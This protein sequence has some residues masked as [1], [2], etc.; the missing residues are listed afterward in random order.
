MSILMDLD[1]YTLT[2][3]AEASGCSEDELL[4]FGST[5]KL[6]FYI[7]PKNW[8]YSEYIHDKKTAHVLHLLRKPIRIDNPEY[9]SCLVQGITSSMIM[10]DE[11]P[12]C[13]LLDLD[14]EELSGDEMPDYSNPQM[15]VPITRDRL[16]I[17]AEDFKQLTKS[18][19][20]KNAKPQ[21]INRINDFNECIALAIADFTEINS[22][23]PTTVNEVINRMKY[24]PPLGFIVAFC[25]KE[26]SINGSMPK[27]I[28]KVERAIK[29]LLGQ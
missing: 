25:G 6:R 28:A 3:A 27:S 17:M 8:A 15:G 26:V 5:G 23:M 4:V 16:V 20:G 18:A 24:N 9:L 7:Q 19:P 14:V 13:T 22:Y 1:Y 11:F 21:T 2:K 29:R 12:S 10:S